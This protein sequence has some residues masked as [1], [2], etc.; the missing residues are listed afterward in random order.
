MST[1]QQSG[2]PLSGVRHQPEWSD[3]SAGLVL[4]LR[5]G[6]ENLVKEANNDAGLAANPS[7][8]WTMNFVHFQLAML[9]YNL[10]CWLWLFQRE[11]NPK[12]EE[13]QHT[14]LAMAHPRF[15][16]G[17]EDLAPLGTSGDQL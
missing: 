4:C 11:E 15:L 16:F 6:A 13:L 17:G 7:R 8:R 9:T 10:N 12:E 2:I 14:T 5:A 1:V 3:R